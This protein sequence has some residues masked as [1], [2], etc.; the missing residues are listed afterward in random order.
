MPNHFDVGGYMGS[1]GTSPFIFNLA[2]GGMV[3]GSQI[4]LVLILIRFHNV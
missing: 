4:P 1:G 3:T 2:M